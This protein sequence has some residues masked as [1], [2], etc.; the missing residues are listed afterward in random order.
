[1]DASPDDAGSGQDRPRHHRAGGGHHEGQAASEQGFRACLGILRLARS[2]G[3]ARIEA[4]CRRG[5]DIGAT[6]YG[7]I[8][9]ILQHGLDRA[10]A[11][12]KPA[13]GPPIQHRNI[14]GTG[15]Y[16]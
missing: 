3:S 7:S 10:Y 9:S 15:Y 1:V 2:Y 14:R 8:K 5:N 4:A 12:D 6:T 11:N 16:H 13:D